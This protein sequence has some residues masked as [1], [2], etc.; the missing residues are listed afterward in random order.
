MVGLLVGHC[1]KQHGSSQGTQW[2]TTPPPPPPKVIQKIS[3]VIPA[4]GG[5]S[6][7]SSVVISGM[8]SEPSGGWG[9]LCA[10]PRAVHSVHRGG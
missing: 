7:M 1:Q 4:G 5:T 2:E 9:A 3:R 10:P 8:V 6:G